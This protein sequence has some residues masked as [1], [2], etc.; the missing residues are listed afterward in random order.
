M[1]LAKPAV[2]LIGAIIFLALMVLAIHFLGSISVE[3]AIVDA[4]V[5]DSPARCIRSTTVKPPYFKGVGITCGAGRN[6]Q[7]AEVA[8]RAH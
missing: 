6:S 1:P 3:C 5:I 7:S 4:D 8:T 2:R